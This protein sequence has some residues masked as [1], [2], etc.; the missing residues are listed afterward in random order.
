MWNNRKWELRGVERIKEEWPK[1]RWII[2]QFAIIVNLVSWFIIYLTSRE[3]ARRDTHKHF[4]YPGSWYF[5]GVQIFGFTVSWMYNFFIFYMPWSS[6]YC[7]YIFFCI[8]IS[9][10]A[11]KSKTCQHFPHIVHLPDFFYT[12]V[13]S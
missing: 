9:A 6:V 12:T 1:E 4:L 3:E 13:K 10:R 11:D 5:F 2:R 7:Y 8:V